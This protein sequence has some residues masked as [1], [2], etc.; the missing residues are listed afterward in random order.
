[1]TVNTQINW[2]HDTS[3]TAEI[4][5]TLRNVYINYHTRKGNV[6]AVRGID[7]DLYSGESLALIGE[8]G[9]GKTTLGLGVVR[10]LADTASV[11]PGEIIYRRNGEEVDVLGLKSGPLREFRWRD[12]A[13]VFQSA[14]NAFNPVLKIWD[15]V[16]DTAKAHNW[17]DRKAVR[18]RFLDL[19]RFV[20]LDPDRVIDSYP[21][22]LSGGMRQRTLLAISLLLDPQILILDEPTTAL[23]ILTQRTIIDLLRKLNYPVAPA[24]LAIVLGPLA[25]RALRQSLIASQ[26]DVLTFVERPISGIIMA[27]TFV[28]FLLPLI[29]MIKRRRAQA[30]T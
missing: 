3:R 13:M 27:I 14:L 19:L 11:E 2:K 20:Q 16:L 18:A 10:L 24:V 26:G 15:Q 7:L 17:N 6:Q 25:E 22:E 9:S 29:Q 30:S 23:D 8:S 1:M 21:H 28:L 12:C 4:P 5:L